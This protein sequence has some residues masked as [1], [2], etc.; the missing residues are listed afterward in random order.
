[1]RNQEE[2]IQEAERVRQREV[3]ALVDRLQELHLEA[4][5]LTDRLAVL[6]RP[7]PAPSTTQR[8]VTPPTVS[9]NIKPKANNIGIFI[10]TELSH[11]VASRL[12]IFIPI[13]IA[14]IIVAAVKYALVSTSNPTA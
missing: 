10:S 4:A 6:T 2:R 13:G 1:M 9:K 8:P 11:N 14:I 12:K 3:Q 7:V 5:E